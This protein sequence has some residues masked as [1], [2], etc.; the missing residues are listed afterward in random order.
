MAKKQMGFVSKIRGKKK[1]DWKY[2]KYVKSIRSEKTG[3]WRFNEMMV[4][5]N[6]GETLDDALKRMATTRQIHHVDLPVI[7]PPERDESPKITAEEAATEE[8]ETAAPEPV[9]ESEK[10]G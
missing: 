9:V 7:E 4:R 10:S 8:K 6:S 1:P 3:H 2:V 5:I